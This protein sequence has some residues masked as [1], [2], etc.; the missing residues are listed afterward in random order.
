MF[1][2]Y[3]ASCK[4]GSLSYRF[5]T[6]IPPLKWEIRKC[7]CSFCS[8]QQ[9][10][11]H[12]SDS[13]GQVAFEISISAYL[14]RYR[15]STRTADFLTCLNCN[16]YLGATMTTQDGSFAVLNAEIINLSTKLPKPIFVSFDGE[17]TKQRITRRTKRWTPV[18]EINGFS[19]MSS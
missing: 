15:F 3:F 9:S 8:K 18:V 1:K 6:A 12:V 5:S 13:L 14:N 4:C 11:L 7:T 2:N 16:S 10:H 17:T 19:K